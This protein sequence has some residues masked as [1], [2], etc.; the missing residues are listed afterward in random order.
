MF[1]GWWADIQQPKWHSNSVK[2]EHRWFTTSW[3]LSD[4]LCLSLSPPYSA[5]RS[6]LHYRFSKW[7]ITHCNVIKRCLKA[8]PCQSLFLLGLSVGVVRIMHFSVY[9]DCEHLQWAL[10]WSHGLSQSWQWLT[11]ELWSVLPGESTE[12]KCVL[13]AVVVVCDMWERRSEEVS[14]CWRD[15]LMSC[16][17]TVSLNQLVRYSRS[18]K[19]VAVMF[20]AV[21]C[22]NTVQL[23]VLNPAWG[24]SQ[25]SDTVSV[26]TCCR[27][28]PPV[29]AV[30][31]SSQC[32]ENAE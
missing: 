5:G 30:L 27:I 8:A 16:L 2:C 11:S 25:L 22:L 14:C 24:S 19:S 28:D 1:I 10:D 31:D 3:Q 23:H 9:I 7:F 21:C 32:G 15:V 6:S 13:T 12:T 20:S 17:F 4:H 29:A 18:V 26:L